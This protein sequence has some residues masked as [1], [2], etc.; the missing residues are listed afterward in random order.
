MVEVFSFI[1]FTILSP[2]FCVQDDIAYE[3]KENFEFEL[4]YQFK[5]KPPPDGDQ[6]SLV[7]GT[8]YRAQ[9]LPYLKVKF[10]FSD[11]PGH[12]FRLKVV[13]SNG[14]VRK[15]KRLKLPETYILDMGYSDDL[16]DRVAPHKYTLFFVTR[17]KEMI[18][19]VEVEVKEDGNLLL[20]GEFHGRI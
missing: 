10:S 13:D 15:N 8:E 3:P 16:K 11:F 4:D 17:E 12:Y 1:V 7:E 2:T 5:V 18:S 6:V 9:P 20:N 14:S 19:K